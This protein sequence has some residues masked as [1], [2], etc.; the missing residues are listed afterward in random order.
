MSG[1]ENLK[2][3]SAAQEWARETLFR[4]SLRYREAI[5]DLHCNQNVKMKHTGLNGLKLG[6]SYQGISRFEFI[7]DIVNSEVCKGILQRKLLPFLKA[8]SHCFSQKD[9]ESQSCKQMAPGISITTMHW[10]DDNSYLNL[11][12]NLLNQMNLGVLNRKPGN[13]VTAKE[14]YLK[15]SAYLTK[16]TD[17]ADLKSRITDA[18]TA[19]TDEMLPHTRLE[20]EYKLDVLKATHGAH[21]VAFP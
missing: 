9:S 16:V 12:E 10:P 19:V 4:P 20:I 5:S 15:N 14:S 21:I 17:I 3:S 7:Q 18:F 6:C 11:I 1:S 13:F 2:K 8:N